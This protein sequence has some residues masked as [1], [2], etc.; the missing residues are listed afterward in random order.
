MWNER[1]K[2]ESGRVLIIFELKLSRM[3][4]E[5]YD[6]VKSS[7]WNKLWKSEKTGPLSFR[8]HKISPW[9]LS[10]YKI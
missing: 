7:P 2:P 3:V 10:N 9:I 5:F 4:L 6:V 1:K 8:F